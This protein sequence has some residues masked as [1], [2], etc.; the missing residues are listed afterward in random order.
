VALLQHPLVILLV[1]AAVLHT[2]QRTQCHVLLAI[3]AVL[4][5][6][7]V[8]QAGHGQRNLGVRFFLVAIPLL[9]LV[10]PSRRALPR[11]DRH[12]RLLVLPATLALA[13][14]SLVS[15]R[16]FGAPQ[17]V[18]LF[19]IAAPLRR[20]PDIRSTVALRQRMVQHIQW[21]AHQDTLGLL[22]HCL[23]SLTVL[24]QVSPAAQL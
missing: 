8:R 16:A 12:E 7:L 1:L 11:M 9:R 23:A 17:L 21:F 13:L 20:P 15:P 2:Q 24:G 10:T 4:L 22:L 19:V 18:V 14:P 5:R 6:F 3:L